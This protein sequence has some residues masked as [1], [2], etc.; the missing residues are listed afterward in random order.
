MI[1]A[2]LSSSSLLSL[3][4]S[5]SASLSESAVGGG[6]CGA[7]GGRIGA[8]GMSRGSGLDDLEGG[9]GEGEEWVDGVGAGGIR[10][11][12][13][14]DSLREPLGRA[15]LGGLRRLAAGGAGPGSPRGGGAAKGTSGLRSWQGAG[16][17]GGATT[18]TGAGAGASSSSLLSSSPP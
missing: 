16:A 5:S 14:F 13:R 12:S 10:L 7:T 17:F 6:G 18:G 9:A 15:I 1:S 11:L 8:G 2:E 4:N 3:S